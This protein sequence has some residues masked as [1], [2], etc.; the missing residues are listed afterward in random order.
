MRSAM[1]EHNQRMFDVSID[2][3]CFE[4]VLRVLLGSQLEIEIQNRLSHRVSQ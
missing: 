2:V 3:N 1:G 4:I